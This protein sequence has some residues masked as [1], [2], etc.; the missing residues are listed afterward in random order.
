M[1]GRFTLRAPA[2]VVAEQFSVFAMPPFTPRFNIAPT[3]PASVVRMAPEREL[4]ALRWGLIPGWAKDPAIGPRLINA[5]A[6]TAAEKPAF[7]AAFRR[8]RC[9]VVADGFYEWQRRGK[10]KQPYF[11]HLR[12]DRPFAF[13]GLWESWERPERGL[14]ETCTILTTEPNALVA[15]LHDRM[16]VIL[17]PDAYD[18]W[19]DPTN[20]DVGQL[21]TLLRAYPA[22]EM[23][24]YPVGSYVNSPTHDG[25]ECIEPV[26]TLWSGGEGTANGR[27]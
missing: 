18:T 5:R 16:P 23:A 26:A 10:A 21:A 7:R 3:Q 8:R 17:P 2:S 15:P 13:A 24:A 12:D 27:G 4:V 20:E 22:E 6:E 14:L 9:L 1:C 11:I 25:A 19:L